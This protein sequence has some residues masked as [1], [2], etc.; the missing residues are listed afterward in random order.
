MQSKYEQLPFLPKTVLQVIGQ[1]ITLLQPLSRRGFGPGIVVLVPESGTSSDSVLRIDEG[2]PSPLMKWAEEGY[3]VVEITEAGLA[4]SSDAL[5]VALRELERNDATVPKNVVGL[6][7]EDIDRVHRQCILS[8]GMKLRGTLVL[9]LCNS[10]QSN[11]LESG[12][13]PIITAPQHRCSIDIHRDR[14]RTGALPC[15]MRAARCWHT[16]GHS[17]AIERHNPIQ[18]SG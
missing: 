3:V 15:T 1:G 10:I 8:T 11:H 9:T 16:S 6:V 13:Q 2:V 14:G 7:G 12:G 18:L 5:A 4:A 17:H